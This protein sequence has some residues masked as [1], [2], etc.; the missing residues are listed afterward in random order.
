MIFLC[1]DITKNFN[2]PTY[3]KRSFTRGGLGGV[4][5]DYFTTSP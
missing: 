2:R 1:L 4:K 5:E 3:A